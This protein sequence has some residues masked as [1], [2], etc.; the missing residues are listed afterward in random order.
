MDHVKNSILPQ[1]RPSVE[2]RKFHRFMLN[3]TKIKKQLTDRKQKKPKKPSK[4]LSRKQHADLGLYTLPTKSLK[5]SDM[6]SLHTLWTQYIQDHLKGFLVTENGQHR[7]PHAYE[8]T[9]DAFSKALV[10]SDFH[11]ANITVIASKSP[12]LVGQNG[13]VAM[14]TKNTF[15]IVGKDNRTRSKCLLSTDFQNR[16]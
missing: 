9:Y 11:G 14:E 5:Y 6:L 16:P 2:I 8:N 4:T 7:I 13:I 10:K 12:T 1:Y 3:G 15:K